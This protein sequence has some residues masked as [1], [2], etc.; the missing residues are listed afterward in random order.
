[1]IK[2]D[3]TKKGGNN[4]L[5][6]TSNLEF[7]GFNSYDFRISKGST[8]LASIGFLISQLKD[9]I[10]SIAHNKIFF[11]NFFFVKN[12]ILNYAFY[13]S[14]KTMYSNNYKEIFKVSFLSKTSFMNSTKIKKYVN[15]NKKGD[16]I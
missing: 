11:L 6:F 2:M 4:A 12:N 14:R 15:K 7:M 16:C 3:G 13:F 8:F 10:L 5:L 9:K 1:M